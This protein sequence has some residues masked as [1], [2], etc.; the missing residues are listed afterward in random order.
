[1]NPLPGPVLP[2]GA[3]VGGAEAGPALLARGAIE[4]EGRRRRRAAPAFNGGGGGQRAPRHARRGRAY[5]G[6]PRATARRLAKDRR[7]GAGGP[8][9]AGL[10]GVAGCASVT[11]NHRAD[12]PTGRPFIGLPAFGNLQIS[13]ARRSAVPHAHV[14]EPGSPTHGLPAAALPS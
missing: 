12:R 14:I 4:P 7:P 3:E 2:A 10:G 5:P 11:C 9:R 13:L 8:D 1:G 6:G